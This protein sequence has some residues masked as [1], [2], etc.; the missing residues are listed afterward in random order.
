MPYRNLPP[1]AFWKPCQADPEFRLF[2]LYLPKFPLSPGARVA[3]AGSCFAQNIG[4]Y[5]RASELELVDVEK[6]PP[7]MPISV[8]RA[9][10]YG[11][12]SARYGNVYTARQLAQLLADMN[13]PCIH[14]SAVWTKDG[15]YF[16]ALRPSCE[17]HGFDTKAELVAPPFGSPQKSAI[18]F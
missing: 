9:F 5:V 15:R 12:Y 8:A 11:L 14:D 13:Q 16:D 2:D 3:T 18:Y 4:R 10:G 6:P 1:H 17:P 7:G